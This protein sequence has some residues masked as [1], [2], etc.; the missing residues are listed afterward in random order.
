[1]L[2]AG[3]PLADHQALHHITAVVRAGSLWSRVGLAAATARL[4]AAPTAR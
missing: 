4:Q 2:L 1:M 3:D